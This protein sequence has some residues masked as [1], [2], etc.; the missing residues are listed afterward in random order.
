MQSEMEPWVVP[1]LEYLKNERAYSLLT[2]QQYD[3]ALGKLKGF[4]E[5]LNDGVT[6]STL[7]AST[8]REWMVFLMDEE[9]QQVATVCKMLSGVRTF[10]RY[11]MRMGLVDRNPLDKV[12]MPKKPKKLPVFVK[13]KE[14]DRLLDMM[15]EDSSFL[16]VRNRLVVMMFYE[17]GMR[18]AELLGLK[19]ADVSLAS[20]EIKV[21]GKRN[22]QRYIPFGKELSE[23]IETYLELRRETVPETDGSFFVRENGEAVSVGDVA[24]V[25]KTNLSMVTTQKKRSPHVLRHS[26]ATAM[27]NNDADLNSIQ[28]LLGHVSI[29]TTEIYTHVTFEDLKKVY[30][31]AHPRS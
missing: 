15:G 22:K 21:T 19:D 1:F 29:R 16:G 31:T 6:W 4:C 7:D 12:E 28:K 14:M 13:E 2:V 27:L 8:V 23:Q 24:N 26:F 30:S 5:S 17:T 10:Y 18:R 11:L 20:R 9:N 3:I 25:V